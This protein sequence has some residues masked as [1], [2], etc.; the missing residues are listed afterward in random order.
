MPGGV[1]GFLAFWWRRWHDLRRDTAGA[2][3]AAIYKWEGSFQ[4][5][6]LCSA[7]VALDLCANELEEIQEEMNLVTAKKQGLQHMC[8]LLRSRPMTENTEQMRASI[9]ALLRIGDRSFTPQAIEDN[10]SGCGLSVSVF[11]GD[12]PGCVTVTFPGVVDIPQNFLELQ[13]RIEEILPCHIGVFYQFHFLTWRELERSIQN[14]GELEK[15]AYVWAGSWKKRE[16]PR[17]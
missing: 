14:W 3:R 7:G 11:E 10:L 16:T 2:A 4:W 6:E 1:R 17:T 15:N 9:S 12:T 5:A 8:S 13:K